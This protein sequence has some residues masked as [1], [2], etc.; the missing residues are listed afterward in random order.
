M[1]VRVKGAYVKQTEKLNIKITLANFIS[2]DPL[3]Q[4]FLEFFTDPFLLSFIKGKK[5]N[6][7]LAHKTVNILN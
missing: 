4:D 2:D 7:E 1:F 6:V 5:L 3:L